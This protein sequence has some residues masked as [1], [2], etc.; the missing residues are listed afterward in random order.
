MGSTICCKNQ[1][2]KKNLRPTLIH[3]QRTLLRGIHVNQYTKKIG[4][5]WFVDVK[6]IQRTKGLFIYFT[7]IPH[8]VQKTRIFQLILTPPGR[9]RSNL[10]HLLQ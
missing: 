5:P 7:Y 1:C 2:A 6:S 9:A 10:M 8:W 4:K 3:S